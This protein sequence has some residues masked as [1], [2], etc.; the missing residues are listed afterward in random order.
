MCACQGIRRTLSP[1]LA[2]EGL[3]GISRRRIGQA[4][5]LVEKPFNLLAE[6]WSGARDPRTITI[7]TCSAEAK[8]LD[9]SSPTFILVWSR[10]LF[11]V[12]KDTTSHIF[13]RLA[14]DASLGYKYLCFQHIH[15]FEF[16]MSMSFTK[17]KSP[18]HPL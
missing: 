13:F 16:W 7:Q 3:L 15:S 9:Q 11:S 2:L 12:R 1:F 8:A 18:C 6:S 5:I 10:S 4:I 14:F 17:T